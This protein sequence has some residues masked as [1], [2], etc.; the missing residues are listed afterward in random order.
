MSQISKTNIYVEDLHKC[1]KLLPDKID[2]HTK[3]VKNWKSNTKSQ[4]APNWSNHSNCIIYK[5]FFVECLFICDWEVNRYLYVSYWQRYE[6]LKV[7]PNTLY[8]I[9]LKYGC[10]SSTFKFSSKLSQNFPKTKVY[11]GNW[12]EKYQTLFGYKKLCFPWKEN[13]KN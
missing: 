9:K 11:F 10:F 1:L 2:K 8:T 4:W 7:I 6:W 13:L 3:S 5:V 12:Q